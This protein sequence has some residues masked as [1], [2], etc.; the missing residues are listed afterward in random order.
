MGGI[1]QNLQLQTDRS[2]IVC[3]IRATHKTYAYQILCQYLSYFAS[4]GK[5]MS[6]PDIKN[7]GLDSNC[8][9]NIMPPTVKREYLATIIFGG[10]SNMAI[11]QRIN[12]A[13]SHT[14]N[15]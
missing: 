14:G 13:I 11:W 10:F 12:L 9:S 4:Y 6:V 2:E 5:K 8:D 15:I 7:L 1:G 3:A